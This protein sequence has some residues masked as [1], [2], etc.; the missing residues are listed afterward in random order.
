MGLVA[1]GP[2]GRLCPAGVCEAHGGDPCDLLGLVP[3]VPVAARPDAR[4]VGLEARRGTGGGG[5]GARERVG[6]GDEGHLCK[7]G[8]ESRGG[9]RRR[10]G[11]EG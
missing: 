11:D 6:V 7:H 1:G 10:N 4:P 3:L 8:D 5:E 2:R 9:Q